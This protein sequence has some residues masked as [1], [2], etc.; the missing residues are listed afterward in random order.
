MKKQKGFHVS[1]GE[2]IDRLAITNI[3]MWHLDEAL[4][5]TDNKV[6]KGEY[7]DI[8]RNLNRE[9]H[10]FKRRN[11]YTVLRAGAEGQIRLKYTGGW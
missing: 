6:K 10:G 4:A 3:K 1:V 9:R 11:Q 8:V 7:A 5:K 2:L